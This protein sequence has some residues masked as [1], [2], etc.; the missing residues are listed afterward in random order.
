MLRPISVVSSIVFLVGW[1]ESPTVRCGA[2]RGPSC[3]TSSRTFF[4]AV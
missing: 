4:G 3:A 2:T 1:L